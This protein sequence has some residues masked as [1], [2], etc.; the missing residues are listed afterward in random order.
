MKFVSLENFVRH[1]F[2]LEGLRLFLDSIGGADSAAQ[3]VKTAF[4]L[5]VPQ[6]VF[7]WNRNRKRAA[8]AERL[9]KIDQFLN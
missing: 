4:R 8:A 1:G 7:Q 2:R 3:I 6:T 9:G 5:A